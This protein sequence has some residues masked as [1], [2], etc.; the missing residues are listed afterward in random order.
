MVNKY[1]L[2]EST[3]VPDVPRLLKNCFYTCDKA[4]VMAAR[5][6]DTVA[7]ARAVGPALLARAGSIADRVPT[8]AHWLTRIARDMGV[9]EIAN[10]MFSRDDLFRMGN[11]DRIELIPEWWKNDDPELLLDTRYGLFADN[12]HLTISNTIATGGL[13]REA[14]LAI[15]HGWVKTSAQWFE[16]AMALDHVTQYTTDAMYRSVLPP[17]MM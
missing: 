2:D 9:N 11:G 7:F 13:G 17:G 16:F 3:A 12:V 15:R 5:E 6:G 4:A 8:V 1:G 14:E 10:E